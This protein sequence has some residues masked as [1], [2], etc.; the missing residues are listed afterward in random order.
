[1]GLHAIDLTLQAPY[2]RPP[3]SCARGSAGAIGTAVRSDPK[4]WRGILSQVRCERASLI[5]AIT[6]QSLNEHRDCVTQ[7]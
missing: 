7:V 4:V 3:P 1:M 5:R 2:Q 6:V